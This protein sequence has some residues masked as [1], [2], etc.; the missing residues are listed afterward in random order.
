MVST[1]QIVF[2]IDNDVCAFAF[3]VGKVFLYLIG[4]VSLA[5]FLVAISSAVGF[6]FCWSWAVAKFTVPP[7]RA[8]HSINTIVLM[9]CLFL[10][11]AVFYLAS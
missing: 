10:F 5:V 2:V 7:S 1:I 11:V 3:G 8:R 4:E 6:C 9:S